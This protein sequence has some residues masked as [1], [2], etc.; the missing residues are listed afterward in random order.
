HQGAAIFNRRPNEAGDFKSP[1]LGSRHPR[2]KSHA[3][4]FKILGMT[5]QT[6]PRQALGLT[7]G[8]YSCGQ[9]GAPPADLPNIHSLIRRADHR[10]TIRNLERL[11]EFHQIGERSDRA[12]TSRRMWIRIHLQLQVFFAL[13]VAP[14]LGEAE[15]EALLRCETV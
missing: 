10:R 7:S 12:E 5:R 9:S 13:I 14:D 1:L 11:L 6:N 3:P 2:T 15:K 8:D 4:V